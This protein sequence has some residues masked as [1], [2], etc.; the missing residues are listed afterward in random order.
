MKFRID[1]MT[2]GGC[3]DSVTM[4]ILWVDPQAIVSARPEQRLVDIDTNASGSSIEAALFAA[5][6]PPRACPPAEDPEGSP[7]KEPR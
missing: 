7:R 6:F 1:N 5:G 3:A 2:C 4:A